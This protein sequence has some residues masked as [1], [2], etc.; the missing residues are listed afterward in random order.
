[1]KRKPPPRRNPM[2]LADR[3][4]VPYKRIATEEAFAPPEMIKAYF[5]LL[6]NDPNVDPGLKSAWGYFGRNP[7]PRALAIRERLQDIGA[8]RIADMDAAGIDRQIVA[9]TSPGT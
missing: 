2:T 5:D 8:R 6:D 3:S 9:L 1:M 7:T 4:A